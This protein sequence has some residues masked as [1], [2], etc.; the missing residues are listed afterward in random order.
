LAIYCAKFYRYSKDKAHSNLVSNS[1]EKFF[2]LY[3]EIV[4]AS[5]GI[6]EVKETEEFKIEWVGTVNYWKGRRGRKP[7]AIV[8]HIT[9]GLMPGCLAW[10]QNF[11]AGVSAN[12]LITKSGEILQ[13]VKDEDIAWANGIVNKPSWPLYDGTNP[14]RY[15]I[16]IEHEGFAGEKLTEEQYQA[17]L[18][19]HRHL[20][21]K[22]AIPVDENHII[23]HYRIDSVNRAN[24]PGAGFPWQRLF[25]DLKGGTGKMTEVKV[26]VKGKEIPGIIINDRAWVPVRDIIEALANKVEWHADTRTVVVE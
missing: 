9:D 1:R 7:V 18:W 4:T 3:V 5:S 17:T 13:L 16:S 10:M 24:C 12:Y 20:T 11:T 15:T 21:E 22:H 25:R 26:V 19:L 6:L 2:I 23:G 8:N 14:N